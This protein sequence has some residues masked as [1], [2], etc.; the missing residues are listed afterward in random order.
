MSIYSNPIVKAWNDNCAQRIEFV[1][2]LRDMYGGQRLAGLIEAVKDLKCENDK[3]AWLKI[4][5]SKLSIQEIPGPKANPDIIEFHS[6]T[7]L[8]ATSDEV[9]WCSAFVN[10]CIDKAGLKGTNSAAARS[11]LDWGEALSEPKEGCI[12]VLRRGNNPAQGHVGFYAGT[13]TNMIR[14][15]GGNQGDKVCYGLF[16]EIMLLSYRWPK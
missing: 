9:P 11:W 5:E 16:P 13:L 4:A 7:T 10:Y 2:Y 14:I 12:V 8:K 6:H 15:L 1:A 3:P